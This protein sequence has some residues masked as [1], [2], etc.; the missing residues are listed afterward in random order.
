MEGVAWEVLGCIPGMAVQQH[1]GVEQF[2]E[3]PAISEKGAARMLRA[4]KNENS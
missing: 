4:T 1:D 3:L 2:G